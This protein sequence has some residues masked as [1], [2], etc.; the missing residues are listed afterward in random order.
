MKKL[1]F[2]VIS[3]PILAKETT[4]V[5]TEIK[6]SIISNINYFLPDFLRIDK[7]KSFINSSITYDSLTNSLDAHLSVRL[8]L[9][10]II[11]KKTKIES[12]NFKEKNLKIKI[13]PF[14]RVKKFKLKA[15]LG[16]FISYEEKNDISKGISNNFY[17]YPF[18][19]FYSENI[20]AVLSK[21]NN[22]F[23]LNFNTD[24]DIFPLITYN[25]GIYHLFINR[26]KEL[27]NSGFEIGG[28]THQYPVIYWYKLFIKYRHIMF[29]TKRA[30]F[31]ITPYLLY[32]K[33]YDF[34]LKP[35]I[36][37]SIN[38]KF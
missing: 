2:L 9:P 37:M 31:D 17:Y 27:L 14:L 24:K 21:N 6:K 29:N 4:Y 16:F 5:S 26:E 36:S 32:S 22:S 34:K 30:F 13:R 10:E 19:N 33:E 1:I 35:A 7:E 25:S 18:D 28:Q 20:S 11:I 3:I 23:S 12:Q 15:F 8:K 38:Y